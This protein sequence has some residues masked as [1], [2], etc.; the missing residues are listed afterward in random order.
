MIFNPKSLVLYPDSRGRTVWENSRQSVK[1]ELKRRFAR[2]ASIN[3]NV[4]NNY[5]DIR[6]RLL[7]LI[8]EARAFKII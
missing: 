3:T 7:D 1:E 2:I 4:P 6:H 8:R 5:L